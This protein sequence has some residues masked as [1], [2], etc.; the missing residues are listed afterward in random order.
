V[1]PALAVLQAL[2]KES[3]E[4]PGEAAQA[5]P[6]SA[7]SVEVL[8]IGGVGGMDRDLVERSGVPFRAIP[9]A[10]VHGVGLRTL[11]ANL[12]QLGRGYLNARRII[13]RFQPQVLL[14]TG[15]YLAVPVAMAARTPMPGMPRPRSLLYVP[16]IEPG[17]AIKTVARFADQIATTVEETSAWL[18]RKAHV[19]VSGYP[20]RKEMRAWDREQ[21]GSYFDLQPGLP[22]L[23]VFGGSK[24]ARSLNE[25]L[26]KILPELLTEMQVIHLTGQL[27]WPQVESIR[28]ALP[29]EIAP[30]YHAYAY[31][32]AE[33]GAAMTIA[34]LVVSRAGASI[35][36]ELPQFGLPAILVPYPYAWRYQKVNAAYL[37]GRGAAV[38]LPDGLLGEKLLEVVRDLI[39]SSHRRVQ[40]QR[41]MVSL[42]RPQAADCIASLIVGLAENSPREGC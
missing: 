10:G 31:L 40:M 29:A 5:V 21:A 17:L 18:P 41:E 33:M 1:Y 19:V 8:W 26:W 11:P 37:E 28:N 36:G 3:L 13:R 20:L 32:H 16:D 14:F 22:V 2:T 15:G 25:A 6:F 9:A 23:L 42:A 39:R 30:R 27:D 4:T 38:V 12:L 35:L 34:D 24:G 7:G